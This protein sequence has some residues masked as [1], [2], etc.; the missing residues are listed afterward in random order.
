MFVIVNKG[1]GLNGARL[2]KDGKWREFACFGTYP[3]CVKEFKLK[4]WAERAAQKCRHS[5]QIRHWKDGTKLPREI[6]VIGPEE[7]KVMDACGRMVEE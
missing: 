6:V 4:G 7:G 5:E 1:I 2:C 3:S